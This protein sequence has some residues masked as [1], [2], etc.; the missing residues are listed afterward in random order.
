MMAEHHRALGTASNFD[1]N[2]PAFVQWGRW[3]D[4]SMGVT[5]EVV[6]SATQGFDYAVGA[7]S[8]SLPTSGSAAR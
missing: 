4:G 6:L 3:A 1:T 7:L 8:P 2:K 5:D